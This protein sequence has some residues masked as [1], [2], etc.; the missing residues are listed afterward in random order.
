MNRLLLIFFFL[1]LFSFFFPNPAFSWPCVFIFL[2]STLFI[3]PPY[4]SGFVYSARSVCG[5]AMRLMR[6]RFPLLP[7]NLIWRRCIPAVLQSTYKP[8]G[9]CYSISCLFPWFIH[10]FHKGKLSLYLV[11]QFPCVTLLCL[12]PTR[13]ICLFTSS[14]FQHSKNDICQF[15]CAFRIYL[16][17]SL[18]STRIILD[19]VLLL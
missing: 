14:S 10:F 17:R 1:L 11:V 5:V 4:F 18:P 2:F 3:S 15:L 13:S 7:G 6:T 19:H 9:R 12:P 8:S 16:I